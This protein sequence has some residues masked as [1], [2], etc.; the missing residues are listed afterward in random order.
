[1]SKIC[2][3]CTE[4]VG[5]HGAR[6]LCYTHYSRRKRAGTL[7]PLKPKPTTEQLF[8]DK[9]QKT[10]TCWLWTGSLWEGYGR[11]TIAGRTM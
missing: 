1:M 10:E 3:D 2:S 9:V 8:W 11:L 6:G 7:P 4:P 5:E